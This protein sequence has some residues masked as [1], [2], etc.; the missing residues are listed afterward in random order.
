MPAAKVK[1][2]VVVEDVKHVVRK[3][4]EFTV[5]DAGIVSAADFE[6]YLKDVYFS[7]GYDVESI[8]YLGPESGSQYGVQ[9]D[10]MKLLYILVK[11]VA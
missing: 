3:V 8:V 5:N 10:P 6:K 1:A 11:R 2:N 7:D 4:G 9:F